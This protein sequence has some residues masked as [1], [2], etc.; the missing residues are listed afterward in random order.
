MQF[1]V[2]RLYEFLWDDSIW[3]YHHVSQGILYYIKKTVS[4]HTRPIQFQRCVYKAHPLF[5]NHIQCGDTHSQYCQ[6]MIIERQLFPKIW[7]SNESYLFDT[8]Y[9]FTKKARSLHKIWSKD[10]NNINS[11]SIKIACAKF[12]YNKICRALLILYQHWAQ[13][14]DYVCLI[15]WWSQ[16]S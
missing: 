2:E 5:L 13:T 1:T 7:M 4:C 16:M 6:A 8:Q 14:S 15:I 12:K 9:L 10:A 11:N 3:E